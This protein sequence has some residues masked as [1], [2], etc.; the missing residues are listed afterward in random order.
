MGHGDILDDIRVKAEFEPIIIE[1][2]DDKVEAIS[3]L[4][5][6]LPALSDEQILELLGLE[7][8]KDDIQKNTQNQQV[9]QEQMNDE[10][11]QTKQVKD[12][13]YK[14]AMAYIEKVTT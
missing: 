12:S 8:M 14:Q 13:F 4:R 7:E 5:L 6:L 9:Q 2:W 10:I 11:K 3:K 1:A